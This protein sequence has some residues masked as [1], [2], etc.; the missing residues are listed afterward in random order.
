MPTWMEDLMEKYGRLQ[1]WREEVQTADLKRN[2]DWTRQIANQSMDKF[3][4]LKGQQ[5]DNEDMVNLGNITVH[6]SPQPQK[7]SSGWLWK[8]LIGGGLLL[9][10][11]QLPKAAAVVAE[12]IN[13][14][15]PA[16]V[17]VEQP[18]ATTIEVPESDYELGLGRPV[19]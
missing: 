16:N 4:G 3:V 5:S 18:P 12:A 14:I 17:I 11:W 15:K 10:G 2:L 13:A 8:A 6:S 19:E 9:T 1:L 7:Q